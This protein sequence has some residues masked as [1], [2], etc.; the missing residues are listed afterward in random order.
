ME[1]QKVIAIYEGQI[2]NET[3]DWMY[4]QIRGTYFR[5]VFFVERPLN[6]LDWVRLIK[7]NGEPYSPELQHPLIKFVPFISQADVLSN[8]DQYLNKVLLSLC[9]AWV[10]GR[11]YTIV[12]YDL[13]DLPYFKVR[14][15]TGSSHQIVLNRLDDLE[16]V[17]LPDNHPFASEPLDTIHTLIS[18]N[19]DSINVDSSETITST[20]SN[21]PDSSNTQLSNPVTEDTQIKLVNYN[22]GLKPLKHHIT[23]IQKE[24]IKCLLFDPKNT[25]DISVSMIIQV[26]QHHLLKVLFHIALD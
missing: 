4:T 24:L 15:H 2:G 9:S 20:I 11:K 3:Q 26:M 18:N 12:G 7:I 19:S 6:Y 8:K 25:E 1:L 23:D 10:V 22:K 17:I 16:V 5:N 21:A 13:D 14:S